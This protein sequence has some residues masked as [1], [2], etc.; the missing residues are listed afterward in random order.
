MNLRDN[1]K[2][3]GI[4]I[5]KQR[6]NGIMIYIYIYIYIYICIYIY[7]PA[8]H[9]WKNGKGQYFKQIKADLNRD[10]SFFTTVWRTKAK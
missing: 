1:I 3:G 6:K 2:Q 5:K 8:V 9:H 10:I 7:N 4:K